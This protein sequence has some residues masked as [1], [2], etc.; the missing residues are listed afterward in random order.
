MFLN[1]RYL[2]CY[3]ADDRFFW[4]KYVVRYSRSEMAN[5]KMSSGSC[6]HV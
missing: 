3:Q 5:T 2:M 6:R 1:I 4:N